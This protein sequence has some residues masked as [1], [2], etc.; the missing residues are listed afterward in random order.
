MIKNNIRTEKKPWWCLVDA[1]DK[2]HLM[3][4]HVYN[5]VKDQPRFVKTYGP[6]IGVNRSDAYNS[7]MK[8][9]FPEFR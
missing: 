7:L 1:K 2:H 6:W 3:P 4:E 5:A 8:E 9:I